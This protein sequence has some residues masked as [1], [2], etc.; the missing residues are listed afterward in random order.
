M[1]VISII[2]ACG[3]LPEQFC[4][5]VRQVSSINRNTF[6]I[7]FLAHVFYFAQ[8]NNCGSSN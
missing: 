1:I 4:W 6:A 5:L 3:N 8:V 7:L 2:P